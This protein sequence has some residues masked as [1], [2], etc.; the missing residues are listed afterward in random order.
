[1]YLIGV[2]LYDGLQSDVCKSRNGCG[3][4]MR[5]QSGRRQ[6]H[7]SSGCAASCCQRSGPAPASSASGTQD[8]NSLSPPA[9][10]PPARKPSGAARA[11]ASR[12][13][14]PCSLRLTPRA[15]PA[16]VAVVTPKAAEPML[17]AQRLAEAR[18]PCRLLRIPSRLHVECSR[19]TLPLAEFVRQHARLVCSLARPRTQ[20][21]SAAAGLQCRRLRRPRSWHRPRAGRASVTVADIVIHQ[22]QT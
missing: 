4:E 2:P 19:P 17:Q 16:K 21:A 12:P 14:S 22:H 20:Q 3:S 13:P 18:R 15:V 7:R 8:T 5:R 6:C 11:P 9:A 1:M 10:R